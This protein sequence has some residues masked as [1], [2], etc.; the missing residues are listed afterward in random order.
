MVKEVT[1]LVIFLVAIPVILIQT[2]LR[3]LLNIVNKVFKCTWH[4]KFGYYYV[5]IIQMIHFKMF[6]RICFFHIYTRQDKYGL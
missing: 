2:L 6:Y 4:T 5:Y 1:V 3:R